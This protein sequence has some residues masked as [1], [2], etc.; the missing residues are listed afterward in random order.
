MPPHD[1]S[2]RPSGVRGDVLA[3]SRPHPPHAGIDDGPSPDDI[4]R[5]NHVT[6]TCPECKK[7]VFDDVLSC[8][9]CGHVFAANTH[10]GPPIWVLIT[11]L[12]LLATLVVFLVLR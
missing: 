2:I 9:H 11:A 7:E 10:K 3:R 5:F 6:R 4:E 12:V 1:R 8:Y